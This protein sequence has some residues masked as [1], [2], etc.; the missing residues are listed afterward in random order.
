MTGDPLLALL[1]LPGVRPAAERACRAIAAMLHHPA[2]QRHWAATAAEASVRAARASAVLDGGSPALPEQG[3]TADPVLTGA[4]RVARALGALCGVWERA[5][6]QVLARLHVLAA[7]DL[8]PEPQLGRPRPV[9]E[10]TARLA[11]LAQLVATQLLPKDGGVAGGNGMAAVVLA[12][13]VHGELLALAPFTH[14]NGVVA[15]GAARLTIVASGLDPGG[16]GVPELAHLRRKRQYLAAAEGF[17]GGGAAPVGGW[18]VHCCTALRA[19]TRE[20]IAIAEAVTL[21]N[22]SRPSGPQTG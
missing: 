19:G 17:A 7:A 10:V 8:A 6:L 12:A 22:G 15:R 13:V 1:A 21:S 5:P 14:A 20:A 2:I 9:A 16:L 11:G 18:I 4:L 3:G